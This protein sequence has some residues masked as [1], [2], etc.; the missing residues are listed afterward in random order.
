[1]VV[2]TWQIIIVI[3]LL[4]SV[5]VMVALSPIR[6]MSLYSSHCLR[7]VAAEYDTLS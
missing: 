5:P 1:M 6:C 7:G 2:P 4:K 3:T